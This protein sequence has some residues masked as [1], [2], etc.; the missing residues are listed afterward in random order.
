MIEEEKESE[1]SVDVAD[2]TEREVL[3]E[4]LFSREDTATADAEFASKTTG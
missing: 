2:L 4:E 3:T 1:I